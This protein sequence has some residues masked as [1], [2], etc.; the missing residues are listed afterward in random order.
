VLEQQKDVT[1]DAIGD[2]TLVGKHR[3]EAE[4]IFIEAFRR[5]NP[6]HIQRHLQYTGELRH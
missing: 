2:H 6:V 4:R 1:A 5:R 3:R